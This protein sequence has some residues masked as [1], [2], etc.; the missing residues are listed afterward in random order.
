MSMSLHDIFFWLI[1]LIING[2][3]FLINYLLFFKTT[4]FLPFITEYKRNQKFSFVSSKNFDVFRFSLELS[5]LLILSCYFNLSSASVPVTVLYFFALTFNLYQYSFRHIY[6]SEPLLLNDLRLLKNAISIAWSEKPWKVIL[7]ALSIPV[8]VFAVYLG[9]KHLLIINA[10]YQA[11]FLFH[12]LSI[13]FF[14]HVIVT[15]K[16]LKGFHEKYPH[17]IW[18]RFHFTVAQFLANLTKS[19]QFYLLTQKKIGKA[20]Q[21]RR[22]NI[23]IELKETPPNIYFFLIESYGSMFYQEPALVASS[24]EVFHTFSNQLNQ[25]GFSLTNHFS[26]S[27]TTGGQSWLAYSSLLFGYRMDNNLLFESHMNDPD[28]WESNGLLQLLKKL[29]YTNYNL[30]PI[31]PVQGINVPYDEMR[32]FYSIDHWL[33]REEVEYDGHLYGFGS[34]PPDQHSLN[35]TME[36]IKKDGNQ[37]HSLFFLTKNSHSPFISP[38]YVEDW[39]SLSPVEKPKRFNKG[40]FSYPNLQDYKTA[41]AYELKLLSE[42]I[43]NNGENNDIFIVMGDHQPP[44]LSDP[45]IYGHSTPV[46]IIS[47]NEAYINEYKTY[48]FRDHLDP[49]ANPIRHESIYS[50][51]LNTFARHYAESN[52]NVPNF[53]P[54]GLLI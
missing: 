36:K 51:F 20:Y 35:Y 5:T 54:E 39:R 37:P 44:L 26:E 2:S 47:K 28:F 33:L 17:D 40:F 46:H 6:E 42:F 48:G 22:R 25:S 52:Y 11:T 29:G 18:M 27:T 10:T 7:L 45:D 24:K 9:F 38:E 4:S 43:T 50:I 31:S 19:Y 21:D 16:T 8:F 34:C 49:T 32:K 14:L 30:N 23:S 41:I 1:F 15:I 53:E 3:L 12:V 13:I